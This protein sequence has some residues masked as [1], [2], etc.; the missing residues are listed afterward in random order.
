MYPDLLNRAKEGRVIPSRSGSIA[1]VARLS[2]RDSGVCLPTKEES[3]L[4]A[5]SLCQQVEE[6]VTSSVS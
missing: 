6:D 4:G 5:L 2:I 3:K 1:P